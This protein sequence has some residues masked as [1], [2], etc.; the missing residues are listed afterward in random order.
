[1]EGRYR[2]Y[3]GEEAINKIASM[4]EYGYTKESLEEVIEKIHFVTYDD[5]PGT[6]SFTSD[7]KDF[8]AFLFDIEHNSNPNADVKQNLY[9]GFYLEQRDTFEMINCRTFSSYRWVKQ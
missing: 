4:P 3:K 1:M 7:S 2:V 9:M 6:E 5:K 8:Y